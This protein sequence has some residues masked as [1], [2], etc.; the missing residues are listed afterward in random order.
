[1]INPHTD[2]QRSS[3]KVNAGAGDGLGLKSHKHVGPQ[4]V[5]HVVPATQKVKHDNAD[6]SLSSGF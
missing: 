5:V 2:L 1:M 4:A 6:V 3:G